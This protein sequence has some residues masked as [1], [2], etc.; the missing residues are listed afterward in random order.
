M[1][2]LKQSVKPSGTYFSILKANLSQEDRLRNL[3]ARFKLLEIT[4]ELNNNSNKRG[5]F[6]QDGESGGNLCGLQ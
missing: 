2:L 4:N 1:L 3:Q 6:N 5:R